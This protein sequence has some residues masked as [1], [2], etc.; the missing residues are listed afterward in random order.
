[1]QDLSFGIN[2]ELMLDANAIA[3]VMQEIFGTEMTAAPA[4]CAGCGNL[5][6]IGALL[7]FTQGPGYTLRCPECKQVML[8]IVQTP[9]SYL[10]DV[11]GTAYL[12]LKRPHQ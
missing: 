6:E 12:R 2:H 4:K 7:A 1:M 9:D 8:R 5:A 10:V 11:R 3:G